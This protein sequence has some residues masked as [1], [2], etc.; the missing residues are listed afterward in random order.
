[1][2]LGWLERH[3][4]HQKVSGSIPIRA[5]SLGCRLDHQPRVY[6]KQP[7]KVGLFLSL[8]PSA[9]PSSLK[10]KKKFKLGFF[11]SF[12]SKWRREKDV[13]MAYVNRYRVLWHKQPSENPRI[14]YLTQND[15]SQTSTP[16]LQMRKQT[17]KFKEL[18]Q[19][20]SRLLLVEM[21]QEQKGLI[22]PSHSDLI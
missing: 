14:F 7:I 3:S 22:N 17:Q 21:G 12:Y 10:K 5:D 18:V 2:W 9:S 1:M 16:W 8:S 15:R 19:N 11:L 13:C 20:L 4:I 6:G